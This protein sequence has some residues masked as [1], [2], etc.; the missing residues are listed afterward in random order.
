MVQPYLSYIETFQRDQTKEKK[1][2]RH[3]FRLDSRFM[4]VFHIIWVVGHI[5]DHVLEQVV[6]RKYGVKL[7]G[8]IMTLKWESLRFMIPLF[9]GLV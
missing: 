1:T 5:F 3:L 8:I 6:A 9:M 7:A 2:C 4:S